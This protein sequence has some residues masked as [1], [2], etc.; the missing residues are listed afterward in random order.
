M[1]DRI[2]VAQRRRHVPRRGDV[3]DDRARRLRGDV[4]RPAQQDADAKAALR[5]LAQEVPADESGGAGERDQRCSH[6]SIPVT[7]GRSARADG[8]S[9]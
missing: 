7:K 2:D 5:Q 8:R 1:N 6:E 4:G 3:A 9:A